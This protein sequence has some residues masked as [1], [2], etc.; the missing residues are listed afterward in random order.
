[1]GSHESGGNDFGMNLAR[2]NQQSIP[3]PQWKV[4]PIK[5]E[6]CIRNYAPSIGEHIK[7]GCLEFM[8]T[9]EGSNREALTCGVC[10]CHRNFHKKE[11]PIPSLLHPPQPVLL[12]N[13]KQNEQMF[14]TSERGEH[15]TNVVVKG[16]RL[17]F[18]FTQVQKG[19]MLE[20][21]KRSRWK[22]Q[23]SK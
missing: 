15:Q 14:K 22:I 17:K 23:K 9:G 3:N 1:M 13:A 12:Y 16:K 5:Y 7:D 10:G 21:A 6:E 20:F 18:K 2:K 4:A 19:K 8:P 11:L